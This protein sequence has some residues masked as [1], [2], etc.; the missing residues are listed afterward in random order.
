M[1]I[2]E[3]EVEVETEIVI[4]VGRG[5]MRGGIGTIEDI[6]REIDRLITTLAVT[7]VNDREVMKGEDIAVTDIKANET[8][9]VRHPVEHHTIQETSTTTSTGD[10]KDSNQLT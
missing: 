4:V 2:D 10:D 9:A 7:V 5:R 1:N 6:N 3:G 8:A